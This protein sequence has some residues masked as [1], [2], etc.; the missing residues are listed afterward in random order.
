MKEYHKILTVYSRDPGTKFKTLIDREF[1]TE[2]FNFLKYCAW[3][4]EE[5]ID[6]TNIRVMWSDKKVLFG[7]KTDNAQ[8]PATLIAVL[9]EMFTP[10]KLKAVFPSGYACL[11]G[12]G[13]GAKIQKGGGDYIPDGQSF[14]LFDVKCGDFWLKREDVYEVSQKLSIK[15]CKIVGIGALHEAINHVKRGFKSLEG[16]QMAEGLVMRPKADLFDRKGHR[17]ITKIKHKD[18]K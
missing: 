5:K 9:Q 7:G 18:F 4:W 10:E 13:Y 16:S 14:I 15:K 12:E 11:Y 6:G 1:A 8:I 17:I 3:E 2:E